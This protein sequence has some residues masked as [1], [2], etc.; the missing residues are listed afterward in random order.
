MVELLRARMGLDPA[1]FGFV[2]S[3][4]LS[5]RQAR[6][7]GGVAFLLPPLSIEGVER[8]AFAHRCMAQKSTMF[9]PKVA[10]GVLFAPARQA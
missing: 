5:L 7:E 1:R 9:L 10:E 6:E 2:A 4:H 3:P 8:E